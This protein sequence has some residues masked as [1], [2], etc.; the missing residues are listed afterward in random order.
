MWWRKSLRLRLMMRSAR[1]VWTEPN[2]RGF[3]SEAIDAGV[4]RYYRVFNNE[5]AELFAYISG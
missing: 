1:L 5:G 4:C 2:A 3:E